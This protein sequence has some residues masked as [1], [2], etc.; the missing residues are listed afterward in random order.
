MRSNVNMKHET[1]KVV[2]VNITYARKGKLN[3][4]VSVLELNNNG[5]T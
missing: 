3:K 4:Y 1:K 2:R 5:I